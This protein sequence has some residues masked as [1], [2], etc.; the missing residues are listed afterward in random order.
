MNTVPLEIL[1]NNLLEL[2]L[3]FASSYIDTFLHEH[4]RGDKPLVES[5]CDLLDN[6]VTQRRLRRQRPG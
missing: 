5:L 4:S 1:R 2:N 3:G 6:E